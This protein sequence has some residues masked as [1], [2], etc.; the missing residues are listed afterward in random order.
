QAKAILAQDTL[1]SPI[2]GVVTQAD[3][4]VGEFIAA[5]QGGFAVQNDN[6]KIEAYV[7]EADIA[8][9]AVGNLA[10]STLDAYGAYT[11]F[12]AKVTMIDPAETVLEGVPTYKVTLV[13]VSP[14][15]RIRSGMTA[16]LEIL[17]HQ[18]SDVLEIP[19][20]AISQTAT[21]T[22]V[23]LVSADGKSYTAVPVVTGLKGSD[24]TIEITSGLKVGDKVVTYVKS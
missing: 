16:N 1:T 3:P 11:N 10:S 21:S 14:D 19:Y 23:R 12:P 8:K 22:T 4:N 6:F 18:A 7:P 2:D 24:G 13:F 20:R 15:S 17:T 5:G 9:V